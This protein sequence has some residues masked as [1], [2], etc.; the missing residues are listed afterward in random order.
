MDLVT[1]PSYQ[2][3]LGAGDTGRFL[4]GTGLS[5]PAGVEGVFEYNDLRMNVQAW[6]DTYKIT[7]LAGFEDSEVRDSRE[8][9]PGDHDETPFNAFY[10]GRTMTIS[11]VIKAGTLQKLRDMVQAMRTAFLDISTEKPLLIRGIRPEQDVI[12][13]CKKNQQLVIP[14]QQNKAVFER[15]FQIP[16]R[17]SKGEYLAVRE[18]YIPIVINAL[19]ASVSVINNGNWPARP[20]FQILGPITTPV[21]LNL[22]TGQTLQLNATIPAGQTWTIDVRRKKLTDQNGANMYEYRDDNSD[23]I[24]ILP[25][26]EPNVI[27]L[28]GSG[29]TPGVTRLLTF[30]RNTW[31]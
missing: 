11:G 30:V 16:L 23:W 25:G 3:G 29:I 31:R 28:T 2:A 27:Q 1:L 26:P 10:G 14:E 19:P 20:R 22:R 24:E 13:Y 18:T 8:A 4:P 21:I 15:T 7:E 9:N 17:A 12:I 5:I 6:L